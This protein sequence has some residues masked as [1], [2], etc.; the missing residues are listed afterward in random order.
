MKNDS[1][2]ESRTDP[3]TPSKTVRLK[4]LRVLTGLVLVAI[5][6]ATLIDLMH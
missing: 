4:A 5:G 3:A 6:A 1:H 2:F